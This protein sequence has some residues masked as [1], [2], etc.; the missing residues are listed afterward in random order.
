MSDGA[1]KHGADYVKI[2]TTV[3]LT[4]GQVV[5]CP[6]SRAA[7]Y[8]GLKNAAVGDYVTLFT[9][10]CRTVAKTASVAFLPGQEV[11]WSVS[12]NKA[13]YR[14]VGDFFV[15]I[16]ESGAAGSATTVAVA[17]NARPNYVSDTSHKTGEFLT[18]AT[19]GL[20]VVESYGGLTTLA[21][22]AVAEVAQAALYGSRSVNVAEKPIWEAELA[23]YDIG[24]NAAL[25]INFGLADASHA[26]DFDS[27][28]DY[29]AFHLDGIDLTF[30]TQ[31][32][33][34]ANPVSADD[35][36]VDAVDDT[37]FFA[38]IDARDADDVKFYVNGVQLNTGATFVLTAS[39]ADMLP[40]IHLEKTSNDTTADIRV[41]RMTLR[42][43]A[44]A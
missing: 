24:D 10:G 6:D 21:F 9:G 37:F 36:G 12:T 33:D 23:V 3:A 7:V 27:L 42:S 40:I 13:T 29:A 34:T 32:D 35:S 18:E 30:K 31:T 25:D 26:T 1:T 14:L 44:A 5:Q 2:V 17:M 20:G 11:W 19:D 22:D 4:S 28:S 39:T 8:N 43:S 41:R 16:A 38:Q 15:G